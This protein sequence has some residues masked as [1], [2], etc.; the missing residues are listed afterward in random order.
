MTV[1]R[2]AGFK[3]SNM[4]GPAPD[5]P[6]PTWKQGIE[7]KLSA[8]STPDSLKARPR[9]PA[10]LEGSVPGEQRGVRTTAAEEQVEKLE[11]SEIDVRKRG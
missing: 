4:S 10:R 8:D 1:P 11:E 5:A 3:Y 6:C 7:S 2:G 9:G